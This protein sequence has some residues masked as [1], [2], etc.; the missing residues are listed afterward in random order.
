[1]INLI[2]QPLG[3]AAIG[4]D[5]AV[6]KKGPVGAG[7]VD[8]LEIYQDDEDFVAVGTGFGQDLAG[9][10]SDEALAPKLD[11]SSAGRFLDADAVGY[12]D[13]T[14]I[15]DGVRALDCFPRVVLRFAVFGF[16][17]GMPA[18]CSW[19]KEHLRALERSQPSAFGVPLVP[20]NQHANFAITCLPCPKTE[21]ARRE[22]ELLIIERIVR[23]MHFAVNAQQRTVRVDHGGRIVVNAGRALLE[24]R[25]DHDDRMRLCEFLK[26]FR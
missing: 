19:I 2:Q 9:S 1:M 25:D 17:F 5:A 23:D 13:V 15:R 7:D 8:F 24:N 6:A 14:A 16:F 26:G 22:V 21:I 12:A 18:D 20:T 11:S 10:A 4:I 3:K